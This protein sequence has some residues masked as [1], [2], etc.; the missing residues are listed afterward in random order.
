MK[1]VGRV[2]ST[3]GERREAEY[4]QGIRE[5]SSNITDEKFGIKRCR[6]ITSRIRTFIT[7]NKRIG[8]GFHADCYLLFEIRLL[9]SHAGRSEH[10]RNDFCASN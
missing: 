4:Q 6:L 1:N 10:G 3:E 5:Y 7:E 8:I 2:I 9:A